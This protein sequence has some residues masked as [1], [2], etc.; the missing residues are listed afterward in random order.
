MT[1]RVAIREVIEWQTLYNNHFWYSL[2]TMD[3]VNQ[4]HRYMMY[5]TER[6]NYIK[7]KK[8]GS[9]GFYNGFLMVNGEK[10]F[11]IAKPLNKAENC[12]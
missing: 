12:I 5:S 10:A 9:I 8:N 4:F 3:L 7:A 1:N 2:D 6:Y 11:K